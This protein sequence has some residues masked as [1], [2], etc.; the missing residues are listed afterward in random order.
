[1]ILS[2]ILFNFGE[3]K[4]ECL[5]LLQLCGG[6]SHSNFHADIS[7]TSMAFPNI[8]TTDPGVNVSKMEI[9]NGTT[10]TSNDNTRNIKIMY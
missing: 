2:F 5:R 10:G 6:P 9:T 8:R 1:M 7:G 3:N 4:R